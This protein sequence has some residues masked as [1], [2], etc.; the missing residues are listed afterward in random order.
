MIDINTLFSV[1]TR[2]KFFSAAL[3]LAE[4]IG[5]PVTSWRAFDPSRSFFLFMS[6]VLSSLDDTVGEY[7]RS[8]FLSSAR[9]DWL[10][11][12]AQEVYGV[13]PA[14]ATYA[15]P[16]VTLTNTGGGFYA[17]DPGD[18]TVK[19]SVTGKTYHNTSSGTLSSGA[20]V[21]FQL[22]AD[23]AGSDSSVAANEIDTLVTTLLGVVVVSS[24]AGLASDAA[25]D[26][27]IRDQCRESL[28]SLSP[29][30]PPDAYTYV[31]KNAEL[32]GQTGIN[33]AAA[34]GSATG[35]VTVTVAS[36]AGAVSAPALAAIQSAIDRWSTPLCVAPTVV[37]ATT[38]TV[39]G[40]WTV[41]RAPALTL[42]S[43]EISSAIHSAIDTLFSNTRIGG[44]NGKVAASLI[45]QTVHNLFPGLIYEVSGVDDVVLTTSQVPV[46][47]TITITVA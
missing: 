20:T 1:S 18:L 31:A 38:K 28:G 16:A 10:R 34:V 21:E 35:A 23:E 43:A 11:L 27:E 29:N 6:E 44:D 32:T 15:E 2:D 41:S 8:G 39:N 5:L 3:D 26:E 40:A 42:T 33:R 14:E 37:S 47:G 7:V 19:N 45:E 22:V 24:T 36:T 46:R 30:G 25:T 13:E 4:T 9:G 12:L 17:L